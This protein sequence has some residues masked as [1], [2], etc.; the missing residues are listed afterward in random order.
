MNTFSGTGSPVRKVD[1]KENYR[2]L[3]GQAGTIIDKRDDRVLVLFDC[4]VDLFGLENHNPVKNI[5]WI[6]RIDLRRIGSDMMTLTDTDLLARYN[7]GQRQFRD[8]EVEDG[9]LQRTDLKN[10]SFDGCFLFCWA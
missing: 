2:K 10:I 7:G 4:E 3:I 1:P 5:L 8:I 9:D 6:L